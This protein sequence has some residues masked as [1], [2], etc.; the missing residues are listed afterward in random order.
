MFSVSPMF[1]IP[2]SE[3]EL[4]KITRVG[5]VDYSFDEIKKCPFGKQT[6]VSKILEVK[7]VCETSSNREFSPSSL[8]EIGWRRAKSCREVE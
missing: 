6:S 1:P 4:R 3:P 2:N 7:P 8:P 5:H